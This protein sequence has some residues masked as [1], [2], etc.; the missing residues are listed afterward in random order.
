[1]EEFLR[2]ATPIYQFRRTAMRDVEMHGQMIRD[3]DKVVMWFAAANRDETVFE[4]PYRFDVTRSPNEHVT[5][6]KGG[7]HFCL[8]AWLARLEL[9]VMFEELLARVG[10]VELTGPVRHVRSN[11]IN[12]IKSMPVRVSLA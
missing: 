6:G 5:F 3:G 12:G 4:D 11:F 2:W 1:M 9:R 8:G 10:D 7:P